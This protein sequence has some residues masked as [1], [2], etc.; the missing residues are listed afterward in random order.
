MFVLMADTL[1]NN[2]NL[3]K[4]KQ[5]SFNS[6]V[7]RSPPSCTFQARL[8]IATFAVLFASE[9]QVIIAT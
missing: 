9:V 6:A 2:R 8:F 5:L 7:Q 3:D 4:L 1:L